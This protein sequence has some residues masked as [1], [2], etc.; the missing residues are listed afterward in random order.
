MALA[1]LSVDLVAR[2]AGLQEGMDKA[3][4]IAEK[5]TAQIEA[6]FSGLKLVAAGV[7]G[8][9]GAAFSVQGL[10]QLFRA[11]IDGVDALNDLADATGS[12]IENLSGLEDVALRS[13]NSIESASNAV[14]KLNKA[15]GEAKPGSDLEAAHRW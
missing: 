2:L 15:L 9:L 7:G 3:V 4:R 14:V 11:T 13:G 6:K 10:T 1:T 12:S 5:S 8:A